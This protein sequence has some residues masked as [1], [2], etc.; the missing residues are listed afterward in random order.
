MR[1]Q[2]KTI[3]IF[4]AFKIGAVFSAIT[5]LVGFVPLALLQSVFLSAAMFAGSSTTTAQQSSPQIDP[6]LFAGLGVAGL[7]IG[8]G[9]GAVFYGL[10]GGVSAVIGAFVYNLISGWIGGIEVDMERIRAE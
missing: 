5:F 10:A 8:V 9:L 3:G 1:V 6:G 4:P 7:C 2:I